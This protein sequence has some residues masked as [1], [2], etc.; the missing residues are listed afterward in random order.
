[1]KW[2]FLGLAAALAACSPDTLPASVRKLDRP[3]DI[4]FGCTSQLPDN[5][6]GDER[7]V[8]LPLSSCAG[9]T[10]LPLP[11]VPG[12][13]AGTTMLPTPAPMAFVL[14]SARGEVVISQSI[15]SSGG[16]DD[17]DRLAPGF[18]G[19]AVGSLPIAI[20]TSADGCVAVTANAGS[21][22][23]TLIDVERAQLLSGGAITPRPIL[24][25]G[26]PFRARPSAMAT[27][28]P[29]SS[30]TLKTCSPDAPPPFG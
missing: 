3:V 17:A 25:N 8:A 10:G 16:L 15:T 26:M 28:V 1:L 11:S 4:A 12:G 2:S 30:D 27:P 20:E 23:L 24:Q 7:T 5:S 6:L 9:T 14:Q 18:N 29:L 22:D 19:L 13:D 21:C